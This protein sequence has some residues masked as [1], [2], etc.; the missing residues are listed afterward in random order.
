MTRR[1]A[2]TPLRLALALAGGCLLLGGCGKGSDGGR[3]KAAA[4]KVAQGESNTID[5]RPFPGTADKDLGTLQDAAGVKELILDGSQ[6]TNEGLKQLPWLPGLTTLSLSGTR[7]SDAGL[8]PLTR[9][10]HLE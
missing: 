9:Y 5:A 7:V 4:Q 1:N 2:A 8:E 3:F 6:V 10:H